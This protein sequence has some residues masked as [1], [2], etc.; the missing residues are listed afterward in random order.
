MRCLFVLIVLFVYAPMA[1]G[2]GLF[3]YERIDFFKEPD[4]QKNT[5]LKPAQDS[6]E[7]VENEW[8]EPVISPSGKMTIYL[9]PKEVRDFLDKPDPENAKAYLEWNLNRIRKFIRAQEMLA[10]E[11]RI[12]GQPRGRD[13]LTDTDSQKTGSSTSIAGDALPQGD[14]LFFF[15]LKGCPVCQ[16]EARV[17]ENIYLTH[18]EIKVQAFAVGYSDDD[19]REFMFPA[20]QDRGMSTLFKVNS[21]PA[22]ALFN[23]KREK[24]FI[25]GYVDKEKILKLFK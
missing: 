17:V 15:M 20:T 23:S 13:N 16:K 5:V 2:Q 4:A 6:F 14:Y 21:Y 12:L 10:K 11:A 25:S 1:C 3:Q 8:A 7:A 24:Y 9:P 19:L 22:I 18:P